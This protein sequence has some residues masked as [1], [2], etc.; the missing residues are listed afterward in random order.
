MDEYRSQVSLVKGR[1]EELNISSSNDMLMAS[2]LL[3]QVKMVKNNVISR[4]E[5]ITRPLMDGLSS[6]RELFQ[7]LEI[8]YTSAQKTIEAKMKT[9]STEEDLRI[10]REKEKI[11][12]RLEKGTIKAETAIT[13]LNSIGDSPE[14]FTSSSG[15]TFIK[16]VPKLRV[17]DVSV[18]PR[19]YLI[20]DLAKLTEA[21]LKQNI[22]VPGVEVYK[23]K[24]I[25]TRRT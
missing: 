18:I 5:E 4:K 3:A 16:Q 11:T 7:P 14:S 24:S 8:G 17:V 1:A 21:V 19:E 6:V 22:K 23:E 12:G 25:V 2:E 9:Y 10:E 13:K 20:P 15:K